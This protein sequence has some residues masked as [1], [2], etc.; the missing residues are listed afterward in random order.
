MN[1][2]VIGM[3][4]QKGRL[5]SASRVY[6]SQYISPTIN[7]ASG[8]GHEPKVLMPR[9]VGGVGLMKSNNG[10][11]FY[12]QDRIYDAEEIALCQSAN[13]QFNPY[14]QTKEKAE[15]RIRRLTSREAWRLMGFT[16]ED[17]DKASQ[18]CSE[19]QLYKQAGNS[20]VVDVLCAIFGEML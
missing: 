3:L 13:E 19:S 14:Y 1:T 16:D 10:T 11:Q 12:Q 15:F 5:E 7:T 20:I 4:Q 2:K 8:G 18:V 17:Y 6:D 9:L